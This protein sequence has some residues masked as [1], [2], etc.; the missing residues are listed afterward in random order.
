M[1]KVILYLTLS[2]VCSWKSCVYE[3]MNFCI[4]PVRIEANVHDAII[5]PPVY[6][7][8]GWK[9]KMFKIL[10]LNVNRTYSGIGKKM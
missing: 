10:K 5:M 9:P 4:S 1:K 7:R 2:Y 6:N 8:L 3:L